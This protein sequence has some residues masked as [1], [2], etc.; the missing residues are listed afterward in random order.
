MP[1]RLVLNSIT[2]NEASFSEF[3][4]TSVNLYG[5]ARQKW[6]YTL[7]G[8][9]SFVNAGVGVSACNAATRC[10]VVVMLTC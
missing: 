3:F 7:S 2:L 9:I 4:A 5:S 10:V 1:V 6:K 8:D